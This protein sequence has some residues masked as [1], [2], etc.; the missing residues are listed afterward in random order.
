MLCISD[1]ID[2]IQYRALLSKV[3]KDKWQEPEFRARALQSLQS[4]RSEEHRNKIRES[5]RAKW[6]DPSYRQKTVVAM[7]DKVS[8]VQALGVFDG[9]LLFH[10]HV[11]VCSPV[12]H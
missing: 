4:E 2:C 7:Q 1:I 11:C 12:M 6:A 8:V 10:V 9:Y 3:M 5:I